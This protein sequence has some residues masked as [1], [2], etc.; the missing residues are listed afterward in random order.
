MRKLN[1]ELDA[2]NLTMGGGI[3]DEGLGVR[4]EGGGMTPQDVTW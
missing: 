1:I 4:D 3:R 2:A